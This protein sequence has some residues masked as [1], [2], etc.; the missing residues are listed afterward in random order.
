M[1]LGEI[2]LWLESRTG[3]PYDFD[4]DINKLSTDIIA[5]DPTTWAL[6]IYNIIGLTYDALLSVDQY[7][8][9]IPPDFPSARKIKAMLAENTRINLRSVVK[10]AFQTLGLVVPEFLDNAKLTTVRNIVTALY[11]LVTKLSED[12]VDNINKTDWFDKYDENHNNVFTDDIGIVKQ[13]LIN[14]QF[15]IVSVHELHDEMDED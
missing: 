14:I 9:Q 7:D 8:Q 11:D 1:M 15:A 10:K 13:D 5:I 6:T 2:Y 3:I 12:N 4:D